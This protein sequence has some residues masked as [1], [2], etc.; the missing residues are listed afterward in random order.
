MINAQ[1]TRRIQL[2]TQYGTA[3]VS[4]TTSLVGADYGVFTLCTDV[5]P[6]TSADFTVQ[7]L[8]SNSTTFVT[9]SAILATRTED[10]NT[11]AMHMLNVYFSTRALGS[12]MKYTVTPSTTTTDKIAASG[13]LTL[14]RLETPPTN[15]TQMTGSTN[16]G[17]VIV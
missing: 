3:A 1:A 14:Y 4:G 5:S 7:L 13:V 12:L 9:T 2:F 15:T 6:T 11:N 17:V 16:D 8:H 10:D